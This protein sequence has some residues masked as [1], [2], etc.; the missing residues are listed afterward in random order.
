LKNEEIRIQRVRC[1]PV[2]PA[3][4]Q[5]GKV[6]MAIHELKP[7]SEPNR[8]MKYYDLKRNW[9]KVRPHLVDKELDDILVED[10]NKYTFGRWRKKFK[11]GRLPSEFDSC[12]DWRWSNRGR[13]PAFWNYTC[14]LACHWLVNFNLRLAMLVMPNK[15]WRIITS[16][17]HSTVWDGGDLLFDFNFQAFGIEPNECFND[18]FKD[19]LAPG[20]YL[21]VGFAK[22][23][24]IKQM[25]EPQTIF[26]SHGGNR[27]QAN[28]Y[29][30][31]MC[32]TQL[33][34]LRV[35]ETYV[36][37]HDDMGWFYNKPGGSHRVHSA[38]VVKSLVETG[39]LEGN[40]RGEKIA[41]RG[42]DEES[43]PEPFLR[44]STKGRTL[45]AEIAED[46]F[47]VVLDDGGHRVVV[48][49]PEEEWDGIDLEDFDSEL[50]VA[51]AHDRVLLLLPGGAAGNLPPEDES[52]HLILHDRVV[53][54]EP[55]PGLE[56]DAIYDQGTQSSSG[57]PPIEKVNLSWETY[58]GNIR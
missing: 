7:D 41:L 28:E 17:R 42:Q 29:P 27:K 48:H 9:Q 15:A 37:W 33:L 6:E 49:A 20:E 58:Q 21:D 3:T 38:A 43:T 16:P 32:Y 36:L 44:T 40:S 51:L 57:S 25:Q 2:R 8:G 5:F 55:P 24:T 50:K 53:G 47:V 14:H 13:R 23:C 18:A 45:L 34:L 19:E 39:L 31:V 52:E 26:S 35:A 1:G 46:G 22:H 10:F 30:E 11:H 54:G 4:K 56:Q 12:V